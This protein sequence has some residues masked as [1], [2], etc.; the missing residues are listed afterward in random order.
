MTEMGSTF[1]PSTT[2]PGPTTTQES[3]QEKTAELAHKMHMETW[4]LVAILVGKIRYYYHLTGLAII[5]NNK[6]SFRI[7]LI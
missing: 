1:E 6:S 7:Q 3:I 5:N 2:I 4:Q